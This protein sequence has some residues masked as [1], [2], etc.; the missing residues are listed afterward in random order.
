MKVM[1]LSEGVKGMEGG[2]GG[3]RHNSVMQLK[4]FANLKRCK[5]AKV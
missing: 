5:G 4:Y 2:G 3:E 1:K